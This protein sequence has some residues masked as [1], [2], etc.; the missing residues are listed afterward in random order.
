MKTWRTCT[1][2]CNKTGVYLSLVA[3]HYYLTFE[4]RC[5]Y[6]SAAAL[7]MR[8]ITVD[9]PLRKLAFTR[10]GDGARA[11]FGVD[12]VLIHPLSES[13]DVPRALKAL[14]THDSQSCESPT[15]VTLVL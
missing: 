5:V 14:E 15:C 13:L 12:R 9:L 4:S 10:G 3:T 2:N 6:F 11:H 7:A 1:T 8:L